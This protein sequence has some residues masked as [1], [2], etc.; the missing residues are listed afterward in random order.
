MVLPVGMEDKQNLVVVEKG[1]D[2]QVRTR[3][4]IG[5]RFS[6]LITSH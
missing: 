2:H 5:V 6:A 3:E 1:D 4:L